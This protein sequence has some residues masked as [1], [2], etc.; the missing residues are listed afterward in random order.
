MESAEETL[1]QRIARLRG[2]TMT[3]QELAD[4]AQVSVSTIRGLEQ[5]QRHTTS[6]R[7]LHRLAAALDV[8]AGTLLGKTRNF[9]SATTTGVQAL[10][11]FLTPVDDLLGAGQLGSDP[12]L[13]E[14]VTE[15]V[16][17][18][19]ELA[20][21]A[22]A[23][24]GG[25]AAGSGP[26]S[27][28]GLVD[29]A[30][31]LYWSG[32]YTTLLAELPASLL[33]LRA[34]AR[35]AAVGE[36]RP[37]ELLARGYWVAAC[38]LVHLGA[39]DS[40]WL[41][42]REAL[43]A[44]GRGGDEL[45]DA[46]LRG[47]VSWQLLVQGRYDEAQRVAQRAA[48]AIEPVGQVLPQHRSV[49][50]SLLISAATAAGRD[51]AADAATELLT[52]AGHQADRNDGIDRND[53]ES[54]FGPAQ[55][56]M[57]T[58]D[59]AVVTERYDQAVIAARAMPRGAALPLAARARHLT[60]TAYAQTMLGDLRHARSALLAVRAMAPDWIRHQSLP[61]Q[62]AAE[63]LTRGDN[64]RELRKLARELHVGVKA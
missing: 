52:E 40:S 50:G 36:T 6:V 3:Q 59:V 13:G 19:D 2:N 25:T 53:Y 21:R 18:D 9:P 41:A 24:D 26:R 34:A 12:S 20:D 5:Q 7:T 35:D 55:V 15:A 38:T 44:A 8:D 46:V 62:V 27:L 60:D 10:R 47:S 4:A 33:A 54:P 23:K 51:G 30:W 31:G 29:Y 48:Q 61:R 11:R 17:H 45:L 43:N 1:G 64:D 42:I 58:V 56:V 37:H 39:S 22:A 32:R 49:Y 14:E 28:P 57:Q 63:L 16:L